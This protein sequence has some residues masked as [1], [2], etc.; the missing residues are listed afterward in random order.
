MFLKNIPTALCT[1][2]SLQSHTCVEP[3]IDARIAAPTLGTFDTI[4][5][6]RYILWRFW[7]CADF[8]YDTVIIWCKQGTE[9]ECMLFPASVD[10][11]LL[12]I[13]RV[14]YVGTPIAA[15]AQS[16]TGRPWARRS[17]DPPCVH[18]YI[19]LSIHYS[20]SLMCSCLNISLHALNDSAAKRTQKPLSIFSP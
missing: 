19:S 11:P 18:V 4:S 13:P 1:F 16:L 9:L 10:T 7:I 2:C 8:S 14:L 5:L 3:I 6:L 12:D 15:D 20:N 17:S